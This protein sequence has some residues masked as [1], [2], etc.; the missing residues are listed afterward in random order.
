MEKYV[1]ILSCGWAVKC[2]GKL[3]GGCYDKTWY[4]T[5]TC[6]KAMCCKKISGCGSFNNAWIITHCVWFVCS[7]QNIK[8]YFSATV[9]AL[10][11]IT[12]PMSMSLLCLHYVICTPQDLVL[13][14]WVDSIWMVESLQWWLV[15]RQFS[16][17]LSENHSWRKHCMKGL[18]PAGIQYYP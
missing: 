11:F 6:H 8:G 16:Y 7:N 1:L 18:R 17:L 4:D 13:N 3:S 12:Q 14:H 2:G 9:S 10:S 15:M 5:D